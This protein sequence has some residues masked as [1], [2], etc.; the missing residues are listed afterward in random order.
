MNVIFYNFSKRKNSTARPSSGSSYACTLKDDTSTARPS[1]A[2]KWQGGGSP[3]SFNYCYI[4]AFGRYY[5]VNSWT[6]SDRQWI[7]D[8]V[9]DVLATYKTQIGSSRKYVL[10]SASEFDKYAPDNKYMPIYPM[11]A[12]TWAMSGIAWAEELGYG[13]FVVGI[14]GQNNTFNAGGV[15]YLVL[16]GA[17]LQ[18]VISACFTGT[19]GIW[20]AASS[21]GAD[22]GEALAKFG[23]NYYKS[24]ASPVQF[25]NSVCWVPFIPETNGSTAIRLG[26]INTGISGACLSN[27]VYRQSW[28]AS[29]NSWNSSDEAWPNV[30]PF[31]RYVLHCPP[32]PDIDIPAE[33]FLPAGLSTHSTGTINGNIYTDVT[34]GLSYLEANAAVGGAVIGAASAQLGVMISL[35]GASVDYAGQISAG[36]GLIGGAISGFL[37][38]GIPG[39][40]GG[41]ISGINGFIGASAP[42]ATGGGY[43]GGLGAIKASNSSRGVIRY[44]YD[45]PELDNAEQGKPL[46][47]VKTLSSLSGY[48]LCADG[49]V[50]CNATEA[51]HAQLEAFLTGGFFY[52]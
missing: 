22:V 39:A 8:C 13:R 18:Q 7:A 2:L 46:L 44:F 25:I 20:T 40:I 10:R 21:L 33:H 27:P 45:V 29:V 5:W 38:G 15:G 12:E 3:A 47:Q 17:Q 31:M 49:E 42:K 50:V 37:S 51:E 14:V 32:F 43:A 28:R 19:E 16:T 1:I 30:E 26:A 6:Y 11:Q 36:A 41:T 35:A 23:E 9:V 52:E 34:N 4:A 48:V 24:I